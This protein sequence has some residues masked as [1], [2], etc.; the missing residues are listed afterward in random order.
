M[1]GATAPPQNRLYGP[2]RRPDATVAVGLSGA[3]AGILAGLTAPFAVVR[4]GAL[5]PV[6]TPRAVEH[7]GPVPSPA[8][9]QT[10]SLPAP[11]GP[12]GR[13]VVPVLVDAA[14]IAVRMPCAVRRGRGRLCG[15]AAGAPLPVFPV[16]SPAA[17][18]A[19]AGSDVAVARQRRVRGQRAPARIVQDWSAPVWQSIRPSYTDSAQ[20]LRA[21]EPRP[22]AAPRAPDARRMRFGFLPAAAA[23]D[24]A[25]RPPSR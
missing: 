13:S 5:L 14:L 11:L 2:P 22:G 17:Q 25:H 7:F 3:V 18:R 9:L 15:P 24:R 12:Q 10:Q 8:A 19:H 20:P 4:A 1:I 21:G 23:H 16:P 6:S